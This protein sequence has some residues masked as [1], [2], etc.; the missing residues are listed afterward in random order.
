MTEWTTMFGVLGDAVVEVEGYKVEGGYIVRRNACMR[1]F[2][3]EGKLSTT[4]LEAE[5]R[6]G[7]L[8]AVARK[9]Q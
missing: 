4:R 6:L 7:D 9:G 5:R 8:A 3:E 2:V 1:E